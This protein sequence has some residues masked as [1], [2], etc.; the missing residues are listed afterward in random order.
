MAQSW[1]WGSKTADKTKTANIQKIKVTTEATLNIT[2]E[3]EIG[4]EELAEFFLN[5]AFDEGMLDAEEFF[6]LRPSENQR[7]F[8]RVYKWI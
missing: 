4:E 5:K 6:I 7:V 2:D 8:F 3:F 1:R